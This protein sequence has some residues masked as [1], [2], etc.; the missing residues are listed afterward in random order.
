MLKAIPLLLQILFLQACSSISVDSYSEF[1]PSFAPQNFFSGYLTAHGVVKNRGGLVIRTFNA[2]IQANWENDI[3]TLIEDFRFDDGEKQ[4]RIW[5]LTPDGNGS[6]LGTA[7]DVI[8]ASQLTFAGNTLFMDYVLSIPYGDS[9]IEVNVDDRM[10]L[11]SS[12]VLINESRLSK[13]GFG[14]GSI[15]LVIIRHDSANIKHN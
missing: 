5:T 13:Y 15:S 3:G 6:Y 7:N 2:D 11:V 9:T 14:V 4:Q 8:G 12:D 10:Y 1:S